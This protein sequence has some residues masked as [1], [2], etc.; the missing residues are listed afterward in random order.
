[1]RTKLHPLRI[2]NVAHTTCLSHHMQ[3]R[4]AVAPYPL[5][6]SP[7]LLL[8]PGLQQQQRDAGRL[9]SFT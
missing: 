5:L 7:P 4:A 9:L 3:A 1:M 6:I 2:A 8:G